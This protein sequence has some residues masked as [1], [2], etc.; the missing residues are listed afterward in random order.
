MAAIS[1]TVVSI[2]PGKMDEAYK[3]LD[4]QSHLASSIDGMIG[5]AVANTGDNELT[6]IGVYE[7]TS[8][9]ESASSLVQPLFAQMASFMEGTPERGVFSGVWFAG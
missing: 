4:S 9:A 3:F 7:S 6:I 1:K 8:A 5:F 2:Q